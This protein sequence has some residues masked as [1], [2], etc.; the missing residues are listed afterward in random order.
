[1]ILTVRTMIAESTPAQA[2]ELTL[3]VVA[4]QF[5]WE[6]RYPAQ[7]VVTAN[8]IHIPAGQPVDVRVTSADVVHSLWVPELAGKTDVIPGQTNDMWLQASQPGEYRGQCAEFCGLQHAHMAFLVIADQ[9][10]QFQQWMS[11]QQQVPPPPTDPTQQR[12]QQV[13]LGSACAYCHTIEGTNASGKIGPDLTHLA[14]RKTLAAGTLPNGPGALGGWI[15]NP[16]NLKP[17][18]LMPATDLDSNDLQALLAY[19]DTLK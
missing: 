17:G 9:S 18:N 14:S 10:D 5:W 11:N 15:L 19:L 3:E 1:M 8:E 7:N 6:V 4:H 12:G 2:N 16:Q 13:F